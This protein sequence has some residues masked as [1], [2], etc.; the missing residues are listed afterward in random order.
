MVL[1]WLK[2]KPMNRR[3]YFKSEGKKFRMNSGTWKGKFLWDLYKKAH[4]PFSWHYD[5]FKLAKK[6]NITLFSSPFSKRAV[7]LLEEFKVPLYKVASFEITDLELIDYIARKRKPIIISTGM[8]SL[9]E[10]KTQ[11]KLLKNITKK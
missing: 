9:K 3:Y 5:A 2:F 6:L 1:I 11:L 10:I 4:T 8:A 7:D